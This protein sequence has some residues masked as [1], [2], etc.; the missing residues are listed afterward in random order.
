MP[1]PITRS[2]ITIR[3]ATVADLPEIRNVSLDIYDRKSSIWRYVGLRAKDYLPVYEQIER[4]MDLNTCAIAVLPNGNVVGF[5]ITLPWVA[6]LDFTNANKA[7]RD[8]H[9][10]LHSMDSWFLDNV[11][12]KKR[13]SPKTVL[14]LLANGTA[15]GYEGLGLNQALRSYAVAKA[16]QAG[17]DM[18]VAETAEPMVQRLLRDVDKFDF[19][20]QVLYDEFEIDGQRPFKGRRGGVVL[21]YTDLA[22]QLSSKKPVARL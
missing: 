20:S 15:D 1:T 8:V 21:F 3:S 12:A 14:R 11:L 6:K 9:G 2:Q 7:S 19:G 4:H 18:L 22:S 17:W 10:I 5:F 16:I 13:R